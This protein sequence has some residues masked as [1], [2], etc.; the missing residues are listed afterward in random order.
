ME[1]FGGPAGFRE[2]VFTGAV[3]ER[4]SVPIK[5]EAIVDSVDI[6]GDNG[7][8]AQKNCTSI[9]EDVKVQGAI[10][11]GSDDVFEIDKY[12]KDSNAEVME[13]VKE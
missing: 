10:K 4:S 1:S 6:S 9:E 2:K 7:A 5:Q 8:S 12:I 11:D 13:A 3:A